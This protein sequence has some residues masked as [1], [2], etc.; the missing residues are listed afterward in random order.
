MI[1]L[2]GRSNPYRVDVLLVIA[3]DVPEGVGV[4]IISDMRNFLSQDLTVGIMSLMQSSARNRYRNTDLIEAAFD[5]NVQILGYR[6]SCIAQ[7]TI[8]YHSEV[9][10]QRSLR[11][12]IASDNVAFVVEEPETFVG[13]GI[14]GIIN[15]RSREYTTSLPMLLA[16]SDDDLQY[17][18]A[19]RL[20]NSIMEWWFHNA[21]VD[22][23]QAATKIEHEELWVGAAYFTGNKKLLAELK[24]ISA[25]YADSATVRLCL[26]GPV[27]GVLQTARD[28]VDAILG[29]PFVPTDRTSFIA[30]LDAFVVSEEALKGINWRID[31]YLCLEFSV[32]V[33]LPRRLEPYFGTSVMYY[34]LSPDEIPVS[35]LLNSST[36]LKSSEF[37]ASRSYESGR[38]RWPMLGIRSNLLFGANEKESDPSAGLARND[39][40]SVK[41]PRRVC[42]V[43]SNGAG[44]GHLTRLLAVARQLDTDITSSFISLSQACGVV[45]EYGYDFEYIA[46]KGDLGVDGAEWN[47]FFNRKFVEALDRANPDV[48]VFDGTWPYQGI[49]KA[50]SSYDAN[51]VWMRRGMWREHTPTTSLIRN[52][53]FH[54][55]IAPGDIAEEYDKGPTRRAQDVLHVNPIV[56]MDKSEILERD[57]ARLELGIDVNA[58][59]ML[60]TLG[61]GN[62]N[63]IDS[64][65]EAVINAARSLDSPW[66]IFITN[67]LIADDSPS[68]E[69][70]HTISIYPLAK[71]AQAFDFVISAT[72]YNSYHEWIAYGVP[73][74]WIANANTITDD[75]IGRA[76]YA[77]DH[78]LGFAAGPGSAVSIE[79]AIYG[80]ADHDLRAGIRERLSARSFENGAHAAAR[81]ISG[82]A[83][84]SSI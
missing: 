73:A 53:E 40:E 16:T 1:E 43:T 28:Q 45:A 46:S 70:I 67:P 7:T 19:C 77:Q 61:A 57:E 10:A 84:E 34:D 17:L 22:T 56:V 66:E 5:N 11:G 15:D 69:N 6:D 74:L 64:D 41:S 37:A 24:G 26:R 3:L 81:H 38:S 82:L 21:Y 80:L 33:L 36:V 27:P 83:R 30:S 54:T 4:D 59:V 65:V 71:Y 50:V 63:K 48:V 18:R 8:F 47:I 14:L 23:D 20:T 44:M 51:F 55:V 9:F 13:T 79:E 62:I 2:M 39:H 25:S 60:I 76:V 52:T 49:A 35:T 78:G 72:G 42:F 68:A 29:Y 32:P 12:K 75:Q 31:T 58:N